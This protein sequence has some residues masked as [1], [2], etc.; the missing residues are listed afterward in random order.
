M[1]RIPGTARSELTDSQGR[2][3]STSFP[4]RQ[5]VD[6]AQFASIRRAQVA[7]QWRGGAAFGVP[8]QM[9]RWAGKAYAPRG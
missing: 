8:P 7:R 2:R 1:H 3:V 4:A 9:A 6:V 5:L